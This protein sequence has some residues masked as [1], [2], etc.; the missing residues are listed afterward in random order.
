MLD[1]HY[2][3]I[4]SKN[5]YCTGYDKKDVIKNLKENKIKFYEK[6]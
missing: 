2:W 5:C 6:I 4:A 3:H 1:Y